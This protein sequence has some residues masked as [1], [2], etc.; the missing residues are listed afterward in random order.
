MGS[1]DRSQPFTT[2]QG[3][4]DGLTR[5]QL[6][7]SAYRTLVRG[8]HVLSVHADDVRTEPRAALLVAAHGQATVSHQTAARLLG[9][10]VPDHSRLHATVPP[11]VK[12]RRREG[13]TIHL[14]TKRTQHFRGIRVTTATQTFLDLAASLDLVDLVVL[15]DSLVKRNRCTP[16]ALTETAQAFSGRGARLARRAAGL[17]RSGVDSPMESRSR[18]LRV[19]AGLPELETDIRFYDRS[20]QLRRRL[21]AGDRAT[22]TGVEYDGRQHI[23]RE[24]HWEADLGRR[25]EFEND[26]WRILTLVSKDIYVSPG[27]TVDR[28]AAIFSRRGIPVGPLRDEWRRHFP[29]RR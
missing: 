18:M 4:T 12:R 7:S 8:I 6:Q 24:Q 2:A 5:R 28:L 20:G 25:E 29:G 17:V 14:G 26:E 22:R 10:V 1:L 11:G 21:D 3:L 23:E 27:A 15:G 13:V 19:L 16:Q 9:G